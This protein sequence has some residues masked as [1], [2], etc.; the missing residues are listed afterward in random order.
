MPKEWTTKEQK[1]FLQEELVVYKSMGTK[2]YSRQWPY[3]LQR[4]S[5]RWPERAATF[6]D[7]SSDDVLSPEQEKTLKDAITNR[8]EVSD[9]SQYYWTRYL[10]DFCVAITAVAALACWS[11]PDQG[12]QLE[13][14]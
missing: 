13:D 14:D 9:G 6:P 2:G 8:H 10:P 3:F 12:C 1:E 11:W 7:L 4:W 5:Q